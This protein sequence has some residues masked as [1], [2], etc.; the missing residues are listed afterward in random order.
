MN[1]FDE[2]PCFPEDDDGPPRR[3]DFFG[4]TIP[5]LGREMRRLLAAHFRAGGLT[6]SW[7]V[8][9]VQTDGPYPRFFDTTGDPADIPEL[10]ADAGPRHF[11]GHAFTQ[12]WPGLF[13]RHPEA[14]MR[15]EFLRAG[16]AD[17]QGIC[18]VFGCACWVILADLDKLGSRP[19]PQSWA[20]ILH[21]RF[22]G[23]IVANG[24]GG[25]IAPLL[26]ANLARD[27]GPEALTALGHNVCAIQGGGEM[28]R[29][30]GS[31]HPNRAALYLLPRFWAENTIHRDSTRMVWPAE[32]AYC[33]PMLLAGKPERSAA[34]SAA[35]ECLTGP[36]W[37]ARL[38]DVHCPTAHPALAHHPL[39]G[40]L[41][42]I[43]WELA[44][45]AALDTLLETARSHFQEG[46]HR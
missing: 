26:A 12:R 14:P 19:L 34:A 28:A 9:R 33:T 40:E 7:Y 25:H 31:R 44:R 32:G 41:R 18:H 43:G 2:E 35:F 13:A 23:D 46:Y 39:P 10:I 37:A 27:F 29:A 20:D 5:P 1:C 3:L 42:W 6:P 8:A 15:A 21:P 4:L 17:P 36:A 30:A 16:L 45:S 11:T 22:R 24:E 38:E